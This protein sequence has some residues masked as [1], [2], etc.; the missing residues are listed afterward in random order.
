MRIIKVSGTA[1][2]RELAEYLRE[3]IG[4]SWLFSLERGDENERPAT[5]EEIERWLAG[6][7]LPGD[8]AVVLE[9][10]EPFAGLR[11]STGVF[12]TDAPIAMLPTGE[13][14]AAGGADLVVVRAGES[15]ASGGGRGIEAAM[16]ESTG[17]GKVLI[18]REEEE[19]DRAFAKALD[20][21][22][23]RL[24]ED[25]MPEDMPQGLVEAVKAASEDG[26][27][28]CG[29]AHELAAEMDV[30]LALVGRALD[31]LDIKITHC[32]LGCF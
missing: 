22:L 27:M 1:L 26:R 29:K 31:L 32:Q 15:F 23:G 16:K 19:R 25:K 4:D 7:G 13:A 8:A 6:T 21:V 5:G 18:Y 2:K 20:V 30:P 9:T 28:S 24:G 3:G 14:E 11:T 12:I 17:A 10:N